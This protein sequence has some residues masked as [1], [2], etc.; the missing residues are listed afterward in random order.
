MSSRRMVDIHIWQVYF[1]LIKTSTRYWIGK[2]SVSETGRANKFFP[3]RI[4]S[5]LLTWNGKR[6]TKNKI[7]FKRRKKNKQTENM[8]NMNLY[9]YGVVR[10]IYDV[11]VYFVYIRL[12][13]NIFYVVY[14]RYILFL[15]TR[16]LL[17]VAMK[18]KEIKKKNYMCSTRAQTTCKTPV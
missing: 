4:F 1:Y 6:W 14:R 15:N 10:N 2:I 13:E 3:F 5:C 18:T 17:N 11:I 9:A 8:L 7:K 12:W 16:R